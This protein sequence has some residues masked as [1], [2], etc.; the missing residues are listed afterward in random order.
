MEGWHDVA[1]AP[2]G[3][4]RLGHALLGALGDLQDL[5]AVVDVPT[6]TPEEIVAELSAMALELGRVLEH[7]SPDALMRPARD[8]GWGVV[9]I[10]PH[11]RDWEEIYLDRVSAIIEQDTPRLPAYDDEL[12]AIERDYR[13]QDSR[14]TFEHF[15]QLR[16]ELVAKLQDVPPKAWG[17]RAVHDIH[18]EITLQW[19]LDR[20][21]DHDREHLDQIRDALT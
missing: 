11:L 6:R 9:E 8:G 14:R 10:L 15:R 16:Q 1:L 3:T 12:W 4:P 7:R 20:I 19:L 13:G 21:C 18:G 17:R 5:S 2:T